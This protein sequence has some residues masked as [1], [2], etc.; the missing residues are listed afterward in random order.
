LQR[1]GMGEGVRIQLLPPLTPLT[2]TLS[3][4]G[5]R[6]H[7]ELPAC[8]CRACDDSNI[9]PTS[10][11]LARRRFS[12]RER[13]AT[14]H[15]SHKCYN[16]PLAKPFNGCVSETRSCLVTPSRLASALRIC[17]YEI[18]PRLPALRRSEHD[19]LSALC[20]R[21]VSGMG[22]GGPILEEIGVARSVE[23]RNNPIRRTGIH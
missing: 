17:S 16:Q 8:S 1:Q 4:N 18:I 14:H 13:W 9:N 10:A 23:P 3:P 11:A 7:T 2:P 5:E 15:Q 20:C 21:D 19:K 6:K 22:L 12:R